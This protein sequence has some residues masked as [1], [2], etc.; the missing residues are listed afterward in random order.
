[1]RGASAGAV[2]LALALAAGSGCVPRGSPYP[3]PDCID[4]ETR[5]CGTDEG[6]CV[7]GTE[8]CTGRAWGACAGA[9]EPVPETCGDGAD[10]DC[11]GAVDEGCCSPGLLTIE[12]IEEDA[13]GGG[14]GGHWSALAVDPEGTAHV[15]YTREG[16][17]DL[18]YARRPREGGWEIETVDADGMTGWYPSIARDAS[19]VLHVVYYAPAAQEL[20]YARRDGDGAAWALEPAVESVIPNGTSM[21]VDGGGV[22]HVAFRDEVTP[23]YALRAPDGT[24]IVEPIAVGEVAGAWAALALDAE[25]VAH[26][27][28][29]GEESGALLHGER[30][31]GGW[32][33]E[34]LDQFAFLGLN[35]AGSAIAAVGTTLYVAYYHADLADLRLAT[36][37][38]PG[39]AWT[40]DTVASAGDVGRSAV[41]AAEPDGALHVAYWESAA[42]TS[43]LRYG[44]RAAGAA[45]FTS[46]ALTSFG[47][48]AQKIALV[49][50][51]DGGAHLTWYDPSAAA[52]RYA[53]RCP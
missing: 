42:F 24:W 31:S 51:A 33:I 50:D 25:G 45:A 19:G 44:R 22:V 13:G 11:D 41:L 32:T 18:R 34:Q 12:T 38:A 36:R 4:G 6:A 9:V 7:A 1:M 47:G 27:T 26:V 14:A 53:H 2:A 23:S 49:A 5:A 43:T 21:A 15:A 3:A 30:S 52:L 40:I 16:S 29:Q 48:E 46:E 8:T 39:A 37:A 35:L 28:F 17:D 10:Q 20:R